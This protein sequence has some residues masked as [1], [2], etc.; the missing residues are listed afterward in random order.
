MTSWFFKKYIYFEK[1]WVGIFADITKIVTFFTQ[2]IF[3]ECRK[4]KD[5]ELQIMHQNAIN[6]CI[7]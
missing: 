4:V 5:K 7:S 6:T 3:K 2:T 1:A